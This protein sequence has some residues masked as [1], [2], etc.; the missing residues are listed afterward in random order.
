MPLIYSAVK[1]IVQNDNRFLV[2][3]QKTTSGEYWD[4]PGG[5]IEYGESP[6]Q[7]LKREVLEETSLN[8]EIERIAGIFYFFREDKHQVICSTFFCKNISTSIDLGNNPA[9]EV[10]LEFKWLT[11]DDFLK[12]KYKVSHQSLKDLVEGVL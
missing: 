3:K 8:I 10:I 5:R 9:E 12:S 6:N 7:A 2:V 11:K 1:A 4:L